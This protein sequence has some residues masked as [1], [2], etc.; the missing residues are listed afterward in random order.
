M[1]AESGSPTPVWKLSHRG[2]CFLLLESYSASVGPFLVGG[3]EVALDALQLYRLSW[4]TYNLGSAAFVTLTLSA[5]MHAR[6]MSYVLWVL[7]LLSSFLNFA[8]IRSLS[9]LSEYFKYEPSL[10]VWLPRETLTS[11]EIAPHGGTWW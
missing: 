3:F 9:K 7:P 4:P 8:L 10:S 11:P 5:Q 6:V 2:G 1:F